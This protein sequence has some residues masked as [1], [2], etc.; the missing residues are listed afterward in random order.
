MELSQL[1]GRSI[2]VTGASGFI[3]SH[4]CRRL[5]A[6]GATVHAVSRESQPPSPTLRW[7]VANLAEA[8]A[9]RTL[10]E[11][12]QPEI[13]FHLASHVAGSRALE[14]VA[15]TFEANLASTVYLLEAATANGCKRFVQAGSLEEGEDDE[16]SAV[17]ASPYA[18]A[19]AA[20]SSYA[21]MFHALYETPVVVARLFMVYGPAQ[22]DLK[23]LIPYVVLALLRGEPVKLSSGTRGVDWVYVDDVV[24]GLLRAALQEGLEGRRVDLG[25]GELVTVR[26]VVEKLF[27]QLAPSERPEFGD[28]ADRPM[29]QVRV[30]RVEE[31]QK[32]LGW[33]PET[34]LNDGLAATIEYYRR[35]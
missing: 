22:H 8:A 25:S 27:E 35:L 12:T 26:G 31:T 9:V 23:K 28:L 11:E 4:L 15:S 6:A 10:V 1:A 16:P 34:S 7:H 30:A 13:F 14:L 24:E 2:L 17:P 33:R 32:L 19:K 20:A 21:R 18:A 29:E 3:G 5:A